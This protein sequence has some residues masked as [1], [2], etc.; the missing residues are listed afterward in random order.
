M[1]IFT[2]LRYAVFAVSQCLSVMLV[3]CI[4]I[5]ED[6]IKLFS[7]PGSPII[8]VFLTPCTDTKFQVEPVSGGVTYTG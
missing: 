3:H 8:L 4:H 6:I 7:R 5:A 1:I 2:A